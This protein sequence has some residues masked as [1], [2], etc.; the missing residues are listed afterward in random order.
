MKTLT[1]TFCAI[2]YIAFSSFGWSGGTDSWGMLDESSDDLQKS[3]SQNVL[4]RALLTETLSC[5]FYYDSEGDDITEAVIN[6]LNLGVDPELIYPGYFAESAELNQFDIAGAIIAEAF[7][8][9]TYSYPSENDATF[10]WEVTG[11]VIIS[12]NGTNQIQ[13]MWAGE[14][15]GSVSVTEIISP[16]CIGEQEVVDVVIMP[17]GNFGCIFPNA[18]NYDPDAET[19]DGSCDFPGDPCSDGNP[20]TTNDEYND[21]CECVGV[22]G[23]EEP[24]DWKEFVMIYPNPTEDFLTITFGKDA[25]QYELFLFDITGKKVLQSFSNKTEQRLDLS[26]FESGLYILIINSSG[27][28]TSKKILLR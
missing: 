24:K 2:F 9:S 12:G 26:P 25:N 4:H 27:K 14:G 3:L 15:L 1:I 8:L 19:N 23:I 11:G 5:T 16:D 20:A 18:C 10:E 13:V 6:L 17:E 22:V 28:S 21:D 7:T